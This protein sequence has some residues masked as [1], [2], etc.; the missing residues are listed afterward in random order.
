MSYADIIKNKAY[1]YASVFMAPKFLEESARSSEKSSRTKRTKVTGSASRH[2]AKGNA[3]S[4]GSNLGGPASNRGGS[5]AG[6]L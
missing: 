1:N 2:K 5:N 3:S 4:K 6:D